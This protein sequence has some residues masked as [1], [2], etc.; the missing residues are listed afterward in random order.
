M[1]SFLSLLRAYRA[2]VV[3]ALL[4]VVAAVTGATDKSPFR[5]NEKAAFADPRTV[6]FVRSGLAVRV[7]SA[8]CRNNPAPTINASA[9][10]ATEP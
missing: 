7:D 2:R 8:D 9:P 6:S 1:K 10:S 3:L 5:P 4:A